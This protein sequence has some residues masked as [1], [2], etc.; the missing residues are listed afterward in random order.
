MFFTDVYMSTKIYDDD[1][2]PIPAL[3][4]DDYYI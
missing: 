1:N 3:T 4:L 2:Y